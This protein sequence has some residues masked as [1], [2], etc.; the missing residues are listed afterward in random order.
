MMP[1]D[2]GGGLEERGD[3]IW[4]VPEPSLDPADP[5]MWPNWR[6]FGALWSVSLYSFVANFTSSSV[7]PAIPFLINTFDPPQSLPS[8]THLIAVSWFTIPYRPWLIGA[9]QP[10]DA[11]GL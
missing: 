7:A 8:L 2:R 9:G 1:S 6:K 10:S 5:L 11:R 4:L 3:H